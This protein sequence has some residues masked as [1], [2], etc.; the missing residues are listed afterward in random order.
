MICNNL[1]NFKWRLKVSVLHTLNRPTFYEYRAVLVNSFAPCERTR[2]CQFLISMLIA[3][4][5]NN[6][7]S[8]VACSGTSIANS[9]VRTSNSFIR[10]I[11][12]L[13]SEGELR[14]LFIITQGTAL[15]HQHLAIF[16]LYFTLKKIPKDLQVRICVENTTKL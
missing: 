6:N 10:L 16:L 8:K 7:L 14:Q 5:Y 2:K 3:L 1:E 12:F 11:H 4:C 13:Q 9:F 15:F